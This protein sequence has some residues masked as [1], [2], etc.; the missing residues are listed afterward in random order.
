L[1]ALGAD[2]EVRVVY[3]FVYDNVGSEHIRRQLERGSLDLVIFTSPSSVS[4]YVRSVGDELMSRASTAAGDEATADA[5]RAAGIDV[6][7]EGGA[8][9]VEG[10]VS[11]IARELGAA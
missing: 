1:I 11:E 6:V 7:V 2:V 10:F 3:R 5:L 9:G 4:Q 8:S